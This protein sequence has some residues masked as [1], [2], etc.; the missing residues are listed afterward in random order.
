M[1]DVTN[2]LIYGV[3]QKLQEDVAATRP[4]VRE[5]KSELTAIRGHIYAGHQDISNIYSMLARHDGRLERIERRL[6]LVSE[7]AL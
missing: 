2:E 7:P 5:I 6:E 3:L 1:A 4:E